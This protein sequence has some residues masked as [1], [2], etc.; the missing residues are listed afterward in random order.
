[1]VFHPK[2]GD[3]EEVNDWHIPIPDKKPNPEEPLIVRPIS[4]STFFERRCLLS[5]SIQEAF[6][7]KFS[8]VCK[9]NTSAYFCIESAVFPIR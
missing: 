3:W 6:S 5:Y 7:R 4:C 8:K 9:A 1:M 2:C